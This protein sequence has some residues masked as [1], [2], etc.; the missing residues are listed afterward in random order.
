MDY[1]ETLK[2]VLDRIDPTFGKT[3]DCDKGWWDLVVLCDKELAS[4]D[5]NYSIF[6]IK[7]KFGGLRY[8]F[9]PSKHELNHEMNRVVAKFEKICAMTCEKTGFHGYLMV[10][11]GIFKT[12]NKSFIND[13]WTE[14][15][16]QPLGQSEKHE[17]TQGS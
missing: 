3:I 11:N 4:I 2:P 13:G 6:Q 1:P 15:Q 10:R 17:S 14:V 12:L 7:E 16:Y 9:K 5:P 8:Y